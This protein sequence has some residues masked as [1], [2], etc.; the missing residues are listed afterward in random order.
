[1]QTLRP[2]FSRFI[3]ALGAQLGTS[4]TLQN[5]VCALNDA[6]DNEAAVIELP[7]HSEMVVFHCRV[8]RCPNAQPICSAC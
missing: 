3:N 6:Q 4:L 2:D 5:G 8:G 1:M 7:E